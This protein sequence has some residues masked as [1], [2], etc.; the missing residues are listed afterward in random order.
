MS[1]ELRRTIRS[2]TDARHTVLE[3]TLYS[4]QT[5]FGET[6]SRMI[7]TVVSELARNILK[8]AG[9]GEV[10]LRRISDMGR[11]GI[12]IEVV[13]QGP[14]IADCEAAMNDHYSSGGTLGLGLPGV[15]RMMDE[16]SLESSLG[17][18]TRV[19]ARKWL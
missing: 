16:F 9:H 4:Q 15:K 1:A 12:E 18:G 17:E 14:G 13:D 2:E 3:S 7:A 10:R 19:W 11:R 8:Y 5:G 6:P